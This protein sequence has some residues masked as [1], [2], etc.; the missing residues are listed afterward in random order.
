MYIDLTGED[1]LDG[2]QAAVQYPHRAAEPVWR[3]YPVFEI[4]DDDEVPLPLR[5]SQKRTAGSDD[6]GSTKRASPERR[7]VSEQPQ[8]QPEEVEENAG[9]DGDDA[10]VDDS[11]D[12]RTEVPEDDNN[13]CVVCREPLGKNNP[14]QLCR[15]T[16]CPC[17]SD[18]DDEDDDDSNSG[19]ITL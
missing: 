4:S 3:S 5:T 7:D 11:D 12:D 6:R 16:Y 17:G 9:D 13:Y 8:Q 2:I 18:Y 14:R 19:D 1:T 10:D 15:R